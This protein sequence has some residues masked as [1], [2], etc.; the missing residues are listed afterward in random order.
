MVASV[1]RS[2]FYCKKPKLVYGEQKRGLR[3]TSEEQALATRPKI[4]KGMNIYQL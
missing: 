4:G 1:C 2:L 3:S